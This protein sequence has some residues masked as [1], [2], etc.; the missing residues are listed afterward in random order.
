MYLSIQPHDPF[1]ARDARPFG[2]GG[3]A[4]TLDWP[5]PSVIAGS[6]RTL[7]G[8]L[9]ASSQDVPFSTEQIKQL[10]QVKITGP[11]LYA[12]KQLFF[13]APRDILLYQEN[14]QAPLQSVVL[15]P[16]AL[17]TEMGCNLPHAELWPTLI[18]QDIKPTHEYTFWSYEAIEQWLLDDLNDF[19]PTED[20]RLKN[21]P[22]EERV[23][24][25]LT[26]D[27]QAEDGKLYQ[28]SGL[29]FHDFDY[30][31][32]SKEASEKSAVTPALKLAI[33]VESETFNSQLSQLK[34][35]HPCGGERR[36]SWFETANI[37]WPQ[38]NQAETRLKHAQ[39]LRMLLLSPAYFA[40]NGWIPDWI[41]A[42][43]L[44]GEIPGTQVK[45][46]LR[47]ACIDRWK[48]LSGWSLEKG[49]RGPKPTRRLVT[50]GSIY[51]FEVL[52]GDPS[53]VSKRWF[54]SVCT[55]QQDINDGFGTALWGVWNLPKK[56]KPHES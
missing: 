45:V 47:S 25:A 15:S 2:S 28:T 37:K 7:L 10:K 14:K 44:E 11:F 30:T 18:T 48:P 9:A 23:H 53:T 36:L 39:G 17:P 42:K 5:Y 40:E 1:I 24:V 32:P 19:V 27:R 54:E 29:L 31:Y 21:L 33:K 16:Q 13:A 35:Y 38:F 41:D 34:A 6:L 12:N 56:E 46:K 8:K 20:Q 43:T 52:A 51:F 49:Q 26:A 55:A 50:A 3:R 22:R 4:R